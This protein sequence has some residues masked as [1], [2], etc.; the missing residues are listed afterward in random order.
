MTELDGETVRLRD[1]TKEDVPALR[2]IAASE[3]VV[4]W[5]GTPGK[6]F[7]FDDDSATPL[8]IVVD[9]GVVGLIQFGEEPEPEY[10]HA[11]IDIF[12]EP[13]RHGRGIC[14]D[15]VGTLA[16]HLIESRGHHRLT[17]DPAADN[18]AAIRCYEKVGFRRVGKTHLSWRD[19]AG[20]WRD[21]MLMELVVEPTARRG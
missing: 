11:W 13:G 7:P 18:A 1:I 14:T 12:I 3:E 15:A 19:P 17:I 2:A 16:R 20:Q 10:R 8:A 21:G 5:W 9:G 6:R 4:R